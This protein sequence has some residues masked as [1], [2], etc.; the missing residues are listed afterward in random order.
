MKAFDD[1]KVPEAL[2]KRQWQEE[3]KNENF[4]FNKKQLKINEKEFG[5][6]TWI[7]SFNG[8]RI[9]GFKIRI[10]DKRC[11]RIMLIET[12]GDK[13]S[14]DGGRLKDL[15]QKSELVEWTQSR[16]FKENQVYDT[17]KTSFTVFALK[18]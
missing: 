1:L 15:F 13:L 4:T 17:L 2:E 10:S 7:F 9:K 18:I 16:F 6:M 12:V 5:S 11:G 3:K 8:K 14:E